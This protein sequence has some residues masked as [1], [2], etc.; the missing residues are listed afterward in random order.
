LP[1]AIPYINLAEAL[2]S[3]VVDKVLLTVIVNEVT[4]YAVILA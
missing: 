4:S 3:A 2:V 1:K